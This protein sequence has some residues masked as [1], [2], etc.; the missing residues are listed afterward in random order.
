MFI[1]ETSQGMSGMKPKRSC[2]YV[3]TTIKSMKFS[4]SNLQSAD[5]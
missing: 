5:H 1:D 4:F 2:G 3:A